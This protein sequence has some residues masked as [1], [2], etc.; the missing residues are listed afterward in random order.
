MKKIKNLVILVI[1]LF[2]F[3]MLNVVALTKP[4]IKSVTDKD[5]DLILVNVTKGDYDIAYYL[6]GE[7]ISHAIKFTTTKTEAY[8]SMPNGTYKIWA[9]DNKGNTSD[10]Y[11]FTKTDKSCNLSGIAG[12][13]GTGYISMCGIVNKNN[14]SKSLVEDGTTLVT[15]AE[16]Y[17]LN[18]TKTEKLSTDCDTSRIDLTT[19]DLDKRICKNT[20]KYVCVKNEGSGT[21]YNASS[22]LYS[23]SLSK[24]TLSPSFN[25]DTY[26]YTASVDSSVSIVYV[27]ATLKDSNASFVS[28]YEPRY[29][30]L[31]EGVNTIL[32]KVKGYIG[33]IENIST[34][35]INITR[36]AKNSGG[37]SS[38][39]SSSGGSTTV[40]KSKVNTL[41]DLTVSSGELS[42]KFNSNIND[43]VV[44][45]DNSV[46]SLTIGATLSDS[47]AKFISDFGPRT[48]SLAEGDN[49]LSIKVQSE[50]GTVRVYRIYV[51]RKPSSVTPSTPENPTN[52]EEPEN[53]TNASKALLKSL[54]LSA[55]NIQFESEEFD[56]SVPVDNDVENIVATA[57]P[58]FEE[59]IVDIIG[60]DNLEVGLNELVIKVTSSTDESV[61]NT[62]TIYI[63][64]NEADMPISTNSLLKSLSI[65]GHPINFDMNTTE[66]NIT[67][68]KSEN[69]VNITAEPDDDVASIV[70]EGNTNLTTGSQIKVRVTAEAGN[71]TDYL[72]NVTGYQKKSNIFLTIIIIILVI[73]IIAYA[74][75][76]A[77][78]YKIVFNLQSIKNFFSNLWN[79]I[80]TKK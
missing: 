64:R 41:S 25:E 13:T 75:L 43:Y 79:S 11:T 67:I 37:S 33:T 47:K 7:D 31:K 9:V 28:G 56:Y 48:V 2:T 14:V 51:Y 62:Y 57:N 38:G 78:G 69:Y 55:G 39:G 29:V 30:N 54:T 17:Y 44:S 20:Y 76:R 15:C 42:P 34:Y 59:D 24:G 1:C 52:P 19:Y 8:L 6:L 66:Y 80:F 61:T 4:V 23:M 27:G 21:A 49:N 36:A 16:G 22:L 46:S 65:E 10:P 26:N 73:L 70:I 32:I 53:P 63:I 58:E 18:E 12:A 40:S 72:I 50:Y 45:V 74:I 68:S 60:G 3:N 35:T 77:L 5:D 71:Y